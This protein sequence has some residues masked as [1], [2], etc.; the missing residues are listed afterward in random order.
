MTSFYPAVSARSTSQL[1]ITRLM[2]QLNNDQNAIQGLQDQL[3]TGRRIT[4]PS[5]DPAAAI[6]ALSAQRQLEFK[7][8]V[9]VNLQ[10]ADTILGATESTLAQAQTILNEMRGL[11]VS[12]AGTTISDEEREAFIAQVQAAV[13]KLADLG[14]S[15]FQDQFI[16][17]GTDLTKPPFELTGD[18]VRFKGNEENLRTITDFSTTIAANVSAEDSFGIRSDRIVSSTDLNPSISGETPLSQ[19]NGGEGVRAGSVSFSNGVTSIEVDLTNA[20]DLNDVLNAINGQEVDGRE[21]RALLTNNS[22]RLD[23]ADGLAGVLIIDEVG[24]GVTASALGIANNGLTAPIPYP[25]SDLD[26]ILTGETLLSQVFD[27]AGLTGGTSFQIQQGSEVFT[28]SLAGLNTVEDLLN[29]INHSGAEVSAAIEPGN[30]SISLQSVESGTQLSIGE[31]GGSLASELGLRTFD[32]TTR[33][34]EL[35]HGQGIFASDLVDDLIITRTDGTDFTIDLDGAETVGDVLGRINNNVNN[36]TLSTRVVASLKA[37]GNGIELTALAGT[38]P[39]RVRSPGG[40][41]AAWGLGLVDTEEGSAA[42]STVAG[43]SLI[44][45]R[46]V[47]GVEVEGVFS[48]LIRMRQAI[49][50]ERPEDMIRITEALDKDIQRVSLARGLIGTRQQSIQYS[51]DLSTE[52]QLQ[53]KQLESNELDADLAQTISD[54]TAREAALQASLQLMGRVNQLTLFNFL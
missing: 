52:Q 14:N 13:T 17:A 34:S 11:A 45:G 31:N 33:L 51:T 40:S 18:A 24:S 30:R 12:A 27:G 16:F 7:A 49:E 43:S 19:L 47:S 32:V 28:I 2:F 44:S 48:T 10:S 36:F 8:Q 35:N 41:Q 39:I 9:D 15:K 22:I 25:G 4:K 54:L 20:Y 38:E 23:Y 26:P 1:A 3:S 37:N 50:S 42:G 5:E 6:K 21:L 46:D 53:L 29:E